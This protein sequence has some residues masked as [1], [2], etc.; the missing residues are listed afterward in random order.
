MKIFNIVLAVCFFIFASLQFNDSPGDV[1]F[2]VFIYSYVG[3]ISA[4]AAFRKYNMWAIVLGL[5]ICVYELFRKFPSIAQWISEGMPS[6]TGEMEASTPHI[7][8]ARE[9][10]GLCLC[11]GVLIY[12]YVRYT[13]L[14]K[15]S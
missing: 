12:H 2:W 10:L 11:F 9:Y 8:L 15:V 1:W 13:K 3:F 6:I 7:E 5:A 4:F 14:R